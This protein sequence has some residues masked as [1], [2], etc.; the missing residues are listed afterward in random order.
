MLNLAAV[1]GAPTACIIPPMPKSGILANHNPL[2]PRRFWCRI[3]PVHPAIQRCTPIPGKTPTKL[4]SSSRIPITVCARARPPSRQGRFLAHQRK[5]RS[6]VVSR[7][8]PSSRRYVIRA[9][10]PATL[11]GGQYSYSH[12]T[13]DPSPNHEP[14]QDVCRFNNCTFLG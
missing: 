3:T 14:F 11:F 12:H 10:S 5:A 6:N 1:G 13:Y 4:V 7:Q 2:R 8:S 9:E